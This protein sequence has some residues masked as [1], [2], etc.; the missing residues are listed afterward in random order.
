MVIGM[1]MV[2]HQG[3]RRGERGRRAGGPGGGPGGGAGAGPLVTRGAPGV[4]R[5]S[6]GGSSPTTRDSLEGA[7]GGGYLASR[8]MLAPTRC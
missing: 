3:W 7:G 8:Q 4:S 6:E 2:V 1:V 5:R